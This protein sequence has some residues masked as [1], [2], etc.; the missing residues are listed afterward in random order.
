MDSI[1]TAGAFLAFVPVGW[2]AGNGLAAAATGP[3]GFALYAEA[4]ETLKD[5][6]AQRINR[7]L[8]I[9]RVVKCESDLRSLFNQ[10]A[11][12]MAADGTKTINEADSVKVTANAEQPTAFLDQF[13]E[14]VKSPDDRK[15][16]AELKSALQAY[17]KATNT[18]NA[19]ILAYI[20]AVIQSYKLIKQPLLLDRQAG[21]ISGQ[22]IKE[23]IGLPSIVAIYLRIRDSSL[24]SIL[25]TVKN[26]ALA[27]R[28][29]CL[30]KP[31]RFSVSLLSDVDE[32]EA[33][34]A[35]LLQEQEVILSNFASVA[36]FTWLYSATD[37]IILYQTIRT[38]ARSPDG[39][40]HG[41]IVSKHEYSDGPKRISA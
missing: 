39:W 20:N 15:A 29:V 6:H 2:L 31:L 33:H 34:I 32:L 37:T 1:V 4:T 28:Y 14:S 21:E 26:S 10:S 30:K 19:D 13:Q 23:N 38:R 36:Q 40:P 41:L 7:N 11:Y 25:R 35:V 16:K 17:T 5:K 12:T 24:V 18:R 9:N 22:L 8:F 3:Q 27:L